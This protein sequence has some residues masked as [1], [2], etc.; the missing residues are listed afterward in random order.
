[1]LILGVII[2]FII[3]IIKSKILKLYNIEESI[4]YRF[5]YTY[6]DVKDYIE[7][8]LNKYYNILLFYSD[9]YSVIF[10]S[11]LRDILNVELSK[12]RTGGDL[13]STDREIEDTTEF[14]RSVR[15]LSKAKTSSRHN[16]INNSINTFSFNKS[17]TTKNDVK[18]TNI[19]LFC[20]ICSGLYT[21][22]LI[23]IAFNLFVSLS[24]SVYLSSYYKTYTYSYS[25]QYSTMFLSGYIPTVVLI[26]SLILSIYLLISQLS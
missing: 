6:D 15:L 8:E 1:V 11:N 23:L 12:G 5:E 2:I 21:F 17:F 20:M 13:I 16:S 10:K 24:L 18:D 4:N 7:T 14:T 22:L 9:N 25:W 19:R 26:V 3:I